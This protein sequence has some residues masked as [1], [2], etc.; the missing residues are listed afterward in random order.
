[1]S[2]FNHANLFTFDSSTLA[3][4]VLRSPTFNQVTVLAARLRKGGRMR[5]SLSWNLG[6]KERCEVV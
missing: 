1:M 6:V 3:Q 5:A 2:R 4:A